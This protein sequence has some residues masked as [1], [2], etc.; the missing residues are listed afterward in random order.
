MTPKTKDDP[1]KYLD[2]RTLARVRTLDS[3]VRLIVEGDYQIR[4]TR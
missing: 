3:K 1:R 4:V 2:P